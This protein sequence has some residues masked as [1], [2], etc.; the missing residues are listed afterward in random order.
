MSARFRVLGL[1][2]LLGSHSSPAARADDAENLERLRS[3]PPEQRRALERKLQELEALP[4]EQKEAIRKLDAQLAAL[5]PETRAKY[6]SVMRRY[7]VWRRTLKTSQQKAIDELPT[8]EKRLE[9]IVQICKENQR[10]GSD[11]A[12]VDLI[13]LELSTMSLRKT[14]YLLKIWA[15]LTKEEREELRKTPADRRL[16]K[17]DSYAPDHEIPQPDYPQ[18]TIQQIMIEIAKQRQEAPRKGGGAGKARAETKAALAAARKKDE[19]NAHRLFDRRE[20]ARSLQKNEPGPIDATALRKFDENMPA[21]LRATLDPLPPD[22]AR[23]R[24]RVLFGLVFPP[25]TK[26]DKIP[27]ALDP[28]SKPTPAAGSKPPTGDRPSF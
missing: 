25:G 13:Q 2:L 1:A 27:D 28:S 22:A 17:L 5:E 24:L 7:H 11:T 12:K 19:E 20:N 9:K 21:F 15:V 23:R 18:A 26:A 4:S 10:G 16:A 8:V 3:M 14:A 6:L